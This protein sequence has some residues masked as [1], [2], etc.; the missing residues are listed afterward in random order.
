MEAC[1]SRLCLCTWLK[2]TMYW[3]QMQGDLNGQKS[4]SW[5]LLQ[6]W[7]IGSKDSTSQCFALLP[8]NS[9]PSQH[10]REWPSLSASNCHLSSAVL[11]CTRSALWNWAVFTARQ[12]MLQINLQIS[13]LNFLKCICSRAIEFMNLKQPNNQFRRKKKK[14]KRYSDE[15]QHRGRGKNTRK[16]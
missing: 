1:Y 10:C 5:W 8:Q 9:S 14:K 12:L 16:K 4:R 2:G 13:R 6:R 7:T 11:C 15:M 3:G